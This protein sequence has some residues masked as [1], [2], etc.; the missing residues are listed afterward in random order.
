MTGDKEY[1]IVSNFYPSLVPDENMVAIPFYQ[2]GR[3]LLES[4]RD[5]SV[6]FCTSVMDTMHQEKIWGGGTLY[7]TIY[8]LKEGDIYLYFFRDYM[9]VLKFNLH[10]EL[11]KNN[12]SLFIPDLFPDHKKAREYLEHYNSIQREL[13]LLKEESIIRDS[14]RCSMITNNLLAN[15]KALISKFSDK[16]FAIGTSWIDK[17]EYGPAIIVFSMGVK[18]TPDSWSAYAI[19]ADAFMRTNQYDLALMNYEKSVALNPDFI[20][21]KKQIEMLKESNK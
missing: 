15:D 14:V 4:R 20:D 9:H 10:K 6:S 8:D 7:T 17:K 12:Y 19:L 21:G 5:T 11:E 3:I 16:I 13:D 2:K 18:L 1:Y